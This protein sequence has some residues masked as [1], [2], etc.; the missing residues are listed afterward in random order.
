MNLFRHI[1]YIIFDEMSKASNKLLS[2]FP[3][4]QLLHNR[5]VLYALCILAL[6]RIVMYGYVKDFNSIITLMLFGFLASFFSKNMIIVLGVAVIATYILNYVP[7]RMISEGA[8]NMNEESAETK[9]D[10]KKKENSA[11]KMSDEK[12]AEDSTE[13]KPEE[14]VKEGLEEQKVSAGAAVA[15]IA[16]GQAATAE[17]ASKPS[18]ADKKKLLYNN[19]QGDFKEFQK[20]QDNILKNMKEIDP[21]LAKAESFISKFEHYGKI[22]KDID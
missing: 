15:G 21:L 17:K 18:T 6:S 12:Q 8:E 5:F 16:S 7:Y 9:T 11:E 1:Q 2:N 4:K 20:I 22:A 19:L 3:G 10:E 13:N 14:N